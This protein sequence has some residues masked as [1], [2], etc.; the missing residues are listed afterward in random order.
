[1]P[2]STAA[3]KLGTKKKAHC[4]T[5][6][7]GTTGNKKNTDERI[8]VHNLCIGKAMQVVS[9]HARARVHTHTHTHMHAC[10]MHT[11]AH[12]ILSLRLFFVDVAGGI[13]PSALKTESDFRRRWRATPKRTVCISFTLL[14]AGRPSCHRQ[15][16][17]RAQCKDNRTS[18]RTVLRY[19]SCFFR[20]KIGKVCLVTV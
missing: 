17:N 9:V 11:H 16:G 8:Q 5:L 19:C 2:D 3:T 13:S 7:R 1:M 20:M 14:I 12:C 15:G 18:R 10:S 4:C 6:S